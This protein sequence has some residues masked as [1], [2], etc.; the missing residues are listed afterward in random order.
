[1]KKIF[2]LVALVAVESAFGGALSDWEFFIKRYDANEPSA[3]EDL[4]KWSTNSPAQVSGMLRERL[5]RHGYTGWYWGDYAR[6]VRVY[7]DWCAHAARL[8]ERQRPARDF[9]M[10]RGAIMGYAGLGETAKAAA[11]CRTALAEIKNLKPAERYELAMTAETI[12]AQ[13]KDVED[14]RRLAEAA[15]KRI[16]AETKA[17]PKVR[18]DALDVVGSYANVANRENLVRALKAVQTA[19]YKPQPKKSYTV[20]FSD[21]PING[22]DGWDNLAAKPDVTYMDRY[23]GGSVEFLVTD[24]ATGDRGAGIGTGNQNG[25][26]RP[27]EIRVVADSWGLHLRLEYFQTN[28]CDAASNAEDCGT[29]EAYLGPGDGQPYNCALIW[30]ARRLDMYNTTYSTRGHRVIGENG[31]GET[32]SN[33]SFT[34]EGVCTY[35]A[36]S[37]DSLA[38]VLPKNGS[39]WDFEVF[40]WCRL[41][42]QPS[43]NGSPSI[44]ARSS[45]GQL[46]F[47][48]PDAAR[49]KMLKPVLFAERNAYRKE[50]EQ[51]QKYGVVCK[52][53]DKVLGDPEFYAA[54]V[55]PMVERL[56]RF[57][58]RLTAGLKDEEIIPFA[59]EALRAWRDFTYVVD[60]KHARWKAEKIRRAALEGGFVAKRRPAPRPALLKRLQDE[61]NEVIGIVHW[62]P[63]T[64]TDREWGYGDEDPMIVAP[65]N[66]SAQQIV[67]SCRDG[68]IGGLV[69]V[70]KHHDGFCLWRTATTEHNIAKSKNFFRGNGDYVQEM[71]RACNRAKVNFGVYVSPWDR[72]NAN[73]G[74]PEYVETFHAQLKELNGG[75]YG[76]VFEMWFDGA[77]G[78]DGWYGGKKERRKIPDGYYR[79]D[80]VFAFLRAMQKDLCIFNESDQADFRF[81]GNERGV[82]GEECRATGGPFDAK[83]WNEYHV[84]CNTG[85]VEGVSFHPAEADFPLRRGWFYHERDRGTAKSA[86]YLMQRYLG[87]VG[88]GGIM[89]L[90]IAPTKEGR[91]D[92]EDVRALKGFQTIRQAFFARPVTTPREAFNVV[93]LK[94]DITDGELVDAYR[95]EAD[96]KTILKGISIGIKRIRVLDEPL[97][98]D[99]VACIVEKSANGRASV[100]LKRYYVDPE[101]VKLVTSA[102]VDDGETDTAKWMLKEQLK[103]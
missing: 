37:W 41:K 12:D 70:A 20:R 77:N 13:A 46:V 95:V 36:I 82:I 25:E 6:A 93:V 3:R 5:W 18:A 27:G 75:R 73:Y 9:S 94:E 68:G 40:R 29:Y 17:E 74:K 86:A 89:N 79:F 54:E 98:A 100:T 28:A 91:L 31:E 4:V 63:N 32:R 49:A 67:E 58:R 96:G 62:G 23:F 71:R 102:K 90:G 16:A 97:K 1:M 33:I 14:F 43:W 103:K 99:T 101:L 35:Y 21:T 87:T 45:W 83:R 50:K 56:D 47:D 80:E 51:W 8:P 15:E 44:H 11:A 10:M 85:L 78:G 38:E 81:P 84:W 52:L 76:N 55:A 48:L 7:D 66:F 57:D 34:K 65:T 42:K 92:D 59:D 26:I 69:F 64:F 88:N 24:I 19:L 61:K 39:V 53:Q 30:N 22:P 72:N 2:L 60:E